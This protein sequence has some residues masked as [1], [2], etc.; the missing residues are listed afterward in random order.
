MLH[1]LPQHA[2][3]ARSHPAVE[4]PGRR[5]PIIRSHAPA[6]WRSNVPSPAIIGSC[7]TGIQISGGSLRN[8]SPKKPG[9]ATP[10]TGERMSLYNEGRCPGPRDLAPYVVCHA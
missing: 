7:C 3:Q 9:G 2:G 1:P 6:D 10:I 4:A 8:V 5:R